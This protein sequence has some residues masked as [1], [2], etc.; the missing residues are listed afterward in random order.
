[1]SNVIAFLE[2]M[3]QDASL[4]HAGAGTLVVALSNAQIDLPM[5]EAIL[6]MNQKQL[7]ALLGVKPNVCCVFLPDKK[8]DDEDEP[9]D[10]DEVSSR[11]LM[12]DIA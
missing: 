3:G 11:L 8:E 6:E 7:E 1:M 12:C 2:T 5:R 9:S 4:A 10:D